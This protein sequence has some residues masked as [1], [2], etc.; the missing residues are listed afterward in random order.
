MTTDTYDGPDAPE[1][2]DA[3]GDRLEV[4]AGQF[5][6]VCIRQAKGNDSTKY[7][8]VSIDSENIPKLVELLNLVRNHANAIRVKS[9]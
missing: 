3:D 1:Y 7:P 5:G 9:S 8:I 6:H 2:L 4:Y